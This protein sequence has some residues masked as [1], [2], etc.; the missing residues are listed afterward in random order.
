MHDSS[1]SKHARTSHASQQHAVLSPTAC[2]TLYTN[3][4]FWMA[5]RLVGASVVDEEETAECKASGEALPAIRLSQ[6]FS[7]GMTR[8]CTATT[9][10]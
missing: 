5:K 10:E 8:S 7:G 2:C 4:R 3:I 9:A 6:E 1:Y